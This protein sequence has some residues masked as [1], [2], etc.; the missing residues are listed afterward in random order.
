MSAPFVGSLALS[1]GDLTPYQLRS[2]FRAL[3]PDVYLP[4]ETEVSAASRARAAW[5]WSGGRGVVAGRSAAAL[6]RSKWVDPRLPAE[7]LWANRR[8]PSGITV[9]SDRVANDERQF[10]AGIAVTTPAR[11]ALDMACRYRLDQA[12]A[13][14]D[15]LARATRLKMAD[16]DAL[17]MRHK[18]RRGILQ[19]REAIALADPGAESPRETWLLLLLIRAGFPAPVTQI[20]IHNEF[21]ALVAVMDMGWEALMIAVEYDG[22]HHRLDRRQFSKDIRRTEIVHGLGWIHLRVTADDTE[23]D[24]LRRAREAFARRV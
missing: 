1:R 13:A 22:D 6:H 16:V 14:I 24:I 23:G 10:V 7:I 17:A 11:T 2:R 18:G 4:R 20:P 8:P 21:G 5:L 19:A 3:Y 12:V 9:W 15:A